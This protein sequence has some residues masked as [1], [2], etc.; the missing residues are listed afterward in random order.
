MVLTALIMGLRA[1]Y[2]AWACAVRFYG[3]GQHEYASFLNRVVYNAGRIITYG[4]QLGLGIAG[5]VLPS[6]S[7]FKSPLYFLR[8]ILVLAGT[9]LLKVN[10]PISRGPSEANIR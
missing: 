9:R 2:T 3:G 5:L 7:K 10:I 1:A 4:L 8:I 6:I